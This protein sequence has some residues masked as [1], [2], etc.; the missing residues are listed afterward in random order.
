MGRGGGKEENRIGRWGAAIE[1]GVAV[2]DIDSV[3]VV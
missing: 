1:V 2:D 3:Q